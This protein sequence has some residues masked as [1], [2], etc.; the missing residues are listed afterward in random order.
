VTDLYPYYANELS[1]ADADVPLDYQVGRVNVQIAPPFRGGAIVTFPVVRVRRI[2]GRVRL[3]SAGG[4]RIPAYGELTVSGGTGP[5]VSPVGS[6]G[7]FYFD[8]L[9]PG[10]HDATVTHGGDVCRFTLVV[11]DA[12]AD[13]LDLGEIRCVIDAP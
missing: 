7:Q 8:S 6:D 12:E 10:R 2:T 4:S 11:P 1:I 5:I 3:V 13:L 9:A